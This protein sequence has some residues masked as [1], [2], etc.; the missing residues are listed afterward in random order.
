MVKIVGLK[1]TIVDGAGNTYNGLPEDDKQI[2]V[3][4]YR[5]VRPKQLDWHQ[6]CIV[7]GPNN[8]ITFKFRIEQNTGKLSYW[9]AICSSKD[10]FDYEIARKIVEGRS[11]K[12]DP[13]LV[14]YYDREYGLVTNVLMDL[15]KKINQAY[16]YHF[17]S[18]VTFTVL[19]ELYSKLR[20]MIAANEK[21]DKD[22][23]KLY[24]A[25]SFANSQL[26]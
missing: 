8:G 11:Q 17:T 24:A 20:R 2:I 22:F 7:D 21:L 12:Q 23:Q 15:D 13:I 6:A 25:I 16:D 18:Q 3:E 1:G 9:H 5:Y 10:C 19:E 4:T 14:D 26:E